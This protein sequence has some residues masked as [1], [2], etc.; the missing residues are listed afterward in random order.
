M[1]VD[2]SGSITVWKWF[3]V[4]LTEPIF[5]QILSHFASRLPKPGQRGTHQFSYCFR[6]LQGYSLMNH[7]YLK[8]HT[9]AWKGSFL[10]MRPAWPGCS[11]YGLSIFSNMN[12]RGEEQRGF[13]VNRTLK[14]ARVPGKLKWRCRKNVISFLKRNASPYSPERTTHPIKTAFKLHMYTLHSKFM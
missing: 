14:L 1:S 6:N 5:W 11:G 7:E 13:D 4:E 10:H 3:V 9:L 2:S 8:Q 12:V